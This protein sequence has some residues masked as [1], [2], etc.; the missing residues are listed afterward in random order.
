MNNISIQHFNTKFGELILGSHDNKLIMCDW[1]HRKAR[2]SIDKRLQTKLKS[3]YTE[4]NNKILQLTRHQLNEYFEHKRENFDI[5]LKLIGTE[6]QKA[7]WHALIKVP[8]GRTFSYLDISKNISNSKAVRAVAN[9]NGA[10]AI[11][12][13]V[14]C[15]RIIGKNGTLTGYAGG[16]NTKNS[17]IKLENS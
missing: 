9:A 16:I 11:S 5:P 6:F 15:H 8:Y 1:Y 13:I 7:V 2:L 4:E 3:S 14:P 12:I 10:N 17:L